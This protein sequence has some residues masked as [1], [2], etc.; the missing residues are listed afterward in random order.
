MSKI[1]LLIV[2]PLNFFLGLALAQ[3]IIYEGSSNG[4]L[5]CM[6]LNFFV[7]GFCVAILASNP[8]K[9]NEKIEELERELEDHV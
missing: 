7:S 8:D 6:C 3:K 5:I 2:T 4:E 1:I 9:K